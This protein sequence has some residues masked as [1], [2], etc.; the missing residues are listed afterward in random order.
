M[1]ENKI[2]IG[3]DGITV[4][5]EILYR[6]SR[7]FDIKIISPFKNLSGGCHIPVFAAL[8]HTFNSEYGD[9][10][11]ADELHFLYDLG[12][13]LKSE[14]ENLNRALKQLRQDIEKISAEMVTE[15]EFRKIRLLLRKQVKNGDIDNKQYQELTGPLR[16]ETEKLELQISLL[17]DSFFEDNF[18]M[19]I[20]V[21]VRDEIID[22]LAKEK[23]I[24]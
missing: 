22:I 15:K 5:G 10:A 17:K 7:D 16:K 20:P 18:P 6:S 23:N 21:G 3:I 1:N 11:I 19:I 12:K 24:E 8:H 13:I 2:E 4:R 14:S 9:E